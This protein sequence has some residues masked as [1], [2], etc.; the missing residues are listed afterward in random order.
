MNVF[1]LKSFCQ[2]VVQNSFM[3]GVLIDYVNCAVL[4]NNE[5]GVKNLTD[6]LSVKN[7]ASCNSQSICKFKWIVAVNLIKI[8]A[9]TNYV[10]HFAG[11]G[12]F[13]L[14][15]LVICKCA[16]KCSHIHTFLNRLFLFL[17][18]VER[19]G[20]FITKICR[21]IV[22]AGHNLAVAQI[23]ISQKRRACQRIYA[24]KGLVQCVIDCAENR[25]LVAEANF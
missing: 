21:R 11:I 23:V 19:I 16:V 2:F 22:L 13:R 5:I 20:Y 24:V 14:F 17:F 18:F 25:T 9:L 6:N 7:T 8:V 3:S 15:G 12:Y 4:F 10:H 1:G